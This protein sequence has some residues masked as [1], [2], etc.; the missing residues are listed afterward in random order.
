M[1]NNSFVLLS[2]Y[3]NQIVM[4]TVFEQKKR[5]QGVEYDKNGQPLWYATED[6]FDR[7]DRKLIEHYG[8]D[9]RIK[10]NQ[11]RVERGMKP[12]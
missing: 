6:F 9:F 8:E 1:V 12:L 3:Q 5:Y 11:S 7:L 4:E 10:L 2:H